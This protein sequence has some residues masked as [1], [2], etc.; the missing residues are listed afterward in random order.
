[1]LTC[2]NPLKKIHRVDSDKLWPTSI[3][4]TIQWF[5]FITITEH[6]ANITEKIMG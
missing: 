6:T 1:M 3:K 5:P 2:I 4:D